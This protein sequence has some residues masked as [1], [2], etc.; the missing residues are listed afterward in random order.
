VTVEL[1]NLPSFADSKT[2]KCAPWSAEQFYPND[3]GSQR[4]QAQRETHAALL[5]QGCLV[6]NECLEYALTNRERYGIWGGTTEEQRE[7]IWRRQARK[8]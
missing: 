5:C 2:T 1:L 7:R 8:R 3:H 6:I 4:T